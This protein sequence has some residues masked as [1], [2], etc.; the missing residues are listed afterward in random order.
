MKAP[1]IYRA[2]VASAAL[3]CS[4]FDVTTAD[5]EDTQQEEERSVDVVVAAEAVGLRCPVAVPCKL[6]MGT[7][8]GDPWLKAADG[9]IGYFEVIWFEA[10]DRVSTS[11]HV[12]HMF[13]FKQQA[14]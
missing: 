1:N 10:T 2:V 4:K 14:S 11:V 7:A 5:T 13:A 6:E 12:L 9:E 3:S 8:F